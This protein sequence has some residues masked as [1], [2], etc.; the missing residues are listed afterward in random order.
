MSLCMCGELKSS[1]PLWTDFLTYLTRNLGATSL[2][3]LQFWQ[4][5]LQAEHIAATI[6]IYLRTEQILIITR[7][8]TAKT[9]SPTFCLCLCCQLRHSQ[10]DCKTWCECCWQKYRN[11]SLTDDELVSQPCMTH[12]QLSFL[13]SVVGSRRIF[14]LRYVVFMTALILFK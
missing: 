14:F 11:V 8:G 13:L 7:E 5:T 10:K 6:R 3:R 1:K 2:L 4:H 12:E 9:V